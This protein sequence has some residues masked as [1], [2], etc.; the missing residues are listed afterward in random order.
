MLSQIVTHMKQEKQLS[1]PLPRNALV[2]II[3]PKNG[4]VSSMTDQKYAPVS[5]VNS[6][7]NVRLA[8]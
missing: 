2:K 5:P 7:K 4:V 3:P 8:P 6:D 1:S